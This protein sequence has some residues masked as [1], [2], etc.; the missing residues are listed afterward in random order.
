MRRRTHRLVVQAFDLGVRWYR[1]GLSD[2]TQRRRTIMRSSARA[3]AAI[4]LFLASIGASLLLAVGPAAADPAD[5]FRKVDVRTQ[6][7]TC[8]GETVELGQSYLRNQAQS[9]RNQHVAR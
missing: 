3:A 4:G 1:R 2:P 7:N 8:N 6:V 9:G 5:I